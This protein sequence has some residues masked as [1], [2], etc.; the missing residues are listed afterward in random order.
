MILNL[1]Y[2][3]RNTWRALEKKTPMLRVEL[4]AN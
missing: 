1:G 3:L 2:T 4:Q